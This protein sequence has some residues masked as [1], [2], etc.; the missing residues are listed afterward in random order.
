MCMIIENIFPELDFPYGCLH[1]DVSIYICYFN[2]RIKSTEKLKSPE[3]VK[4][5]L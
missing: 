3:H 4:L 1:Y 5:Q 2:R